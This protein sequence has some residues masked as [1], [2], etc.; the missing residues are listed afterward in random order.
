MHTYKILTTSGF[1]KQYRPKIGVKH[2]LTALIFLSFTFVLPA[3]DTLCVRMQVRASKVLLK[4]VARGKTRMNDRP[5]L[6]RVI[7]ENNDATFDEMGD[8]IIIDDSITNTTLKM[9]LKKGITFDVFGVPYVLQRVEPTGSYLVFEKCTSCS[10]EMHFLD[11]FPEIA[12]LK[13]YRSPFASFRE[14]INSPSFDHTY[15]HFFSK[16][17][18]SCFQNLEYFPE[19][20]QFNTNV[21]HICPDCDANDLT[22]FSGKFNF[23][24]SLYFCNRDEL[25]AFH[26]AQKYPSHVLLNPHGKINKIGGFEIDPYFTLNEMFLERKKNENLRILFIGNS[27]LQGNVIENF[28]KIGQSNHQ[29]MEIQR[30]VVGGASLSDHLSLAYDTTGIYPALVPRTNEDEPLA[31]Q[32]IQ[33]HTWDYIVLI[34]PGDDRAALERLLALSGGKSKILISK[35]FSRIAWSSELR[36]KELSKHDSLA[37]ALSAAYGFGIID[38]GGAFDWLVT[39]CVQDCYP[40]DATFHLSD[41]G[42]KVLSCLIYQ[43][44]HGRITEPD[45]EGALGTNYPG[46]KACLMEY[47][48]QRR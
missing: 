4:N 27:Y 47:L 40:F 42:E 8:R 36:Q 38:M 1:L 18:A 7:D 34:P 15:I 31:V 11:T 48:Q 19:F 10:A 23:W 24:G 26:L 13:K 29:K 17:C 45:I 46:L 3:Q 2:A 6:V 37:N 9:P 43:A 30:A 28:K 12:S 32:L 39:N 44:I 20:Q 5:L 21:I 14:E 22:Y 41:C 16:H 35:H 33:S 25:D